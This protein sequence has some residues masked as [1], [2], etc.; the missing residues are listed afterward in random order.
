V[1]VRRV[2]REQ[3]LRVGAVIGAGSVGAAMLARC[4]NGGSASAPTTAE[5]SRGR[6]PE[7]APGQ[8]DIAAVSDV[9]PSSAVPYTNA[10]NGL[11]EVLVRLPDGRF[12][13][14]SA[15]CSHQGCTWRTGPRFESSCV[16]ATAGSTTQ[17]GAGPSSLAL[18]RHP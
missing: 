3:L 14:Y 17:R 9:A 18:P 1:S 7:T 10:E 15:V 11:P 13:A 5:E 2:S 12:V 4:G 6:V 16:R 8:T